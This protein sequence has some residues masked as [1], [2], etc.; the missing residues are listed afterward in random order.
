MSILKEAKKDALKER[1]PFGKARLTEH[2]S[3]V[4][5]SYITCHAPS[6]VKDC[7]LMLGSDIH[8]IAMARVD[9]LR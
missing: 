1:L 6:Q 9:L 5:N 7:I 8:D 4:E 3:A 2:I